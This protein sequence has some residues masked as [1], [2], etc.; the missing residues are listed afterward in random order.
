[1]SALASLGFLFTLLGPSFLCAAQA[2]EWETAPVKPCTSVSLAKPGNGV[3]YRGRV[4][5]DDY[6]LTLVIPQNL[7]GWGAADVA[8]FHGFTIFLPDS[9]KLRACLVVEIHLHVALGEDATEQKSSGH[10]VQVG[11]IKGRR[12]E[13]TGQL[14]GVAFKNVM[15]EFSVSRGAEVYDG[16]VWL[17]TLLDAAAKNEAILSV[18]LSQIRFGGINGDRAR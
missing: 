7:T 5:N 10:E 4:Q 17:V 2:S 12:Q 8:P 13:R 3:S 9:G 14:D 15:V 6:G 1:M 18:F 16:E 11:N